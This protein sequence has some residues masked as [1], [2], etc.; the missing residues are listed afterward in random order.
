VLLSEVIT[1]LKKG[2][3]FTNINIIDFSCSTC[4]TLASNWTRITSDVRGSH[5]YMK[6]YRSYKNSSTKDEWN[7]FL[8]KLD[9]EYDSGYGSQELFGTIWYE[10]GTWSDRGE[11]DGS[12]WYEYHMCPEVPSELKRIDRV[13]DNKIN[14]IIKND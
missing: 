9:F 5:P 11:Y 13:R 8:N 10:D 1:L 6:K 2:Y 7:E 3:G 4:K 12:E 14:E